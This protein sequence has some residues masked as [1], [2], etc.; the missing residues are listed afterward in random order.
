MEDFGMSAI[1]VFFTK[2]PSFLAHQKTTERT[3]DGNNAERFFGI[4]RIPCDNQIRAMLDPV[5]PEAFFP[6]Y[7]HIY[8]TPGEHG[9]LEVQGHPRLQAYRLGRYLVS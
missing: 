6:V 8:D 7:E 9:I 2:S 5:P 1:S 3:R 4:E